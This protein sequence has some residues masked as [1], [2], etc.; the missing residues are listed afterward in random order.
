ME[1][2]SAAEGRWI[3]QSEKNRWIRQPEY[4]K[5]RLVE[6]HSL[7]LARPPNH[8]QKAERATRL[9]PR[10]YVISRKLGSPCRSWGLQHTPPSLILQGSSGA[11]KELPF[12][13]TLL[14]PV[15]G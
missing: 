8:L 7:W 6:E 1:G 15:M 13:L 5:G 10:T 11:G 3:C 2:A 9:L 12:L 14:G 4:I